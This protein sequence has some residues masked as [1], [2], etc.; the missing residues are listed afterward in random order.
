MPCAFPTFSVLGNE[1]VECDEIKVG[2]DILGKT[3]W[4]EESMFILDHGPCVVSIGMS[5]KFGGDELENESK[6]I[7]IILT[8]SQLAMSPYPFMLL[9]M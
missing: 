6:G 8:V 2:K 3:A 7:D 9:A 4:F 5:L 1:W